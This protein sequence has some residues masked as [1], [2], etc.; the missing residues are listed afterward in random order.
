MCLTIN[1][2]SYTSVY[3]RIFCKTTVC[4]DRP[5]RNAL[6]VLGPQ[7]RAGVAPLPYA[8]CVCVL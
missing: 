6:P 5:Q 2:R 8:A 3:V 7:D 4:E 1:Q